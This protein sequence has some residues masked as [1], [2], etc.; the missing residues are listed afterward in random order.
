VLGVSILDEKSKAKFAA[1]HGLTEARLKVA[2]F[3]RA[4]RR[5]VLRIEIEHH[6]RARIVGQ[7]MLVAVLILE[8][9]RRSLLARFDEWHKA[10]PNFQFPTPK[11]TFL[12]GWKVEVGS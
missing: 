4:A 7:S 3:L 1:K 11:T 2:R 6:V 12:G 5:V 9:E 10:I 8:R